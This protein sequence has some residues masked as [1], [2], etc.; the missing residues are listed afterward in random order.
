M[1]HN[2]K[3]SNTYLTSSGGRGPICLNLPFLLMVTLVAAAMT[4]CTGRFEMLNTN[5]NEVTA[6]QME[7]NNYRVGTKIVSMQ[8]LVIPVEEHMYQFN[9]SLTGGPFAGYI[10]STVDTWLTRFETFNPSADWRKW[11]FSNV[12]T[13]FYTPYRGIV[14]GTDDEVANAFANL[15]RV[16]VL[17]RVTDSYGP[18]P[19]S[20]ALRNESITIKYDSQEDVYAQMFDELDMAIAAFEANE[21]LSASAWSTYDRVYYGN[22]SQWIRYANSLKLR[23]A[24]RISYADPETA[25][26]KA[27]EA[28]AGGVILANA[29]NAYM[30]PTENRMTLIYNDWQDHR[31]GADILC[32]MMGYNDPRTE[33]MFLENTAGTY[34]GVR[35]GSTV[36]RKSSF[37]ES[38][39]N[40]IVSSDTPILW[41]N[42]AEV[43]FLL[44]EYYLRFAN[45]NATARTY[46]ENGIRLSFEEW[47]ATGVDAYIA[48]ATSMPAVYTDPLGTYTY[49]RRMSECKIAW[50]TSGDEETNLEQIITQKW[51][52]IFPLGTEAW[53]EYRR[54]G[55]PKLLPAVQ[56]LGSD[57]VDLNHH[58]RR[59]PYP[60]EEYQSNAA[61]V[62]EAVTILNTESVNGGGDSMGTRVWWDCKPYQN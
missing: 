29:D 3:Y 58:A 16:A 36:A 45:D 55:Y 35:I 34:V 6:G 46:Y 39:S 31:V 28:I 12:I 32:Y 47:G 10:G 51:I 13:E 57:N 54:T 59:L 17:N 50:D 8:S 43:S 56:N 44:A 18:I 24:M 53:C 5:P 52:A 37:V 20:D 38:Y 49:N 61:N 48:D 4:S 26:E 11:P 42:A 30:H 9:E 19:Y 33:K 21:N 2:I 22:I 62:D 1:E 23:L 27:D 40:L 60:V 14:D 7:A 25:R 15:M 41:L